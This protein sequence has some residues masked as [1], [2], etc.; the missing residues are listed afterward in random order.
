MIA[1]YPRCWQDAGVAGGCS[2]GE[3]SERLK[4]HAWKVCKR[5]NPAS[6]V[7]I[8]L[9][10]PLDSQRPRAAVQFCGGPCRSPRVVRPST[11]PG[12]EGS[13]GRGSSGRR[14]V[15][16][17]GCHPFGHALSPVVG[18]SLSVIGSSSAVICRH[19]RVQVAP[20]GA[21][22][23]ASNCRALPV[24]FVSAKDAKD[25]K[26]AGASQVAWALRGAGHSDTF[27]RSSLRPWRPLRT[28]MFCSATCKCVR[29][30]RFQPRSP[31]AGRLQR[32][33]TESAPTGAAV[34][35]LRRRQPTTDNRHNA[36]ADIG[37]ARAAPTPIRPP[38]P[39]SSALRCW[40]PLS[41]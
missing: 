41:R 38:K 35:E 3:M 15:A 29:W 24:P 18:C 8:L 23:R 12:P 26:N 10:P 5:L 36:A 2:S 11:P 40:S 20:A 6:R 32:S 7:R 9:S 27:R 28:T 16:G 37:R 19:V 39:A 14:G 25:A 22:V 13:N 21:L 30:E 31:A 17:R 4:E 33:P 34:C 1:G